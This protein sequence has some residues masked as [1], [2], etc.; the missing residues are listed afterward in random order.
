MTDIEARYDALLRRIEAEGV[1]NPTRGR[2]WIAPS[3]PYAKVM[4]EKWELEK[5]GA[6]RNITY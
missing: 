3:D 2:V 1:Q 6:T 4:R 5:L